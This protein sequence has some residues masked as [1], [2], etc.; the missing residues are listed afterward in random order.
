MTAASV[1]WSLELSVP[2]EEPAA[3]PVPPQLA[4]LGPAGGGGAVL[5]PA[6]DDTDQAQV[7]GGHLPHQ[8]RQGGEALGRPV[9]TEDSSVRRERSS[10]WGRRVEDSTA[11]SGGSS[12]GSTILDSL[13]T[14]HTN[15]G[16]MDRIN[17]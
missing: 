7:P 1:T 4:V 3:H 17:C 14:R 11:A 13:Q 6:V 12:G 5:Q 9:S 16:R 8:P 2:V 10:C 15:I